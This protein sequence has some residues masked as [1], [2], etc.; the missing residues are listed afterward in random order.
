MRSKTWPE[1]RKKRIELDGGVCINCGESD[2]LHVH[3]VVPLSKG[4]KDAMSNLRTL[5]DGCHNNAHTGVPVP[6]KLT[7]SD[8]RWLP[9][10]SEVQRTLDSTGHPLKR[11]VFMLFAKIGV[12]VNDL[13]DLKVTDLRIKKN[14]FHDEDALTLDPRDGVPEHIII[15]GHESPAPQGGGRLSTA[16]VPLDRETVHELRRWLAIR[17]DSRGCESLFLST[18]K[19]GEPLTTKAARSIVIGMAKDVGLYEEGGGKYNLT[20]SVLRMFFEDRFQGQPAVREYIVG[21]KKSPPFSFDRIA[22]DYREGIYK[23]V[24]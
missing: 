5:C 22:T 16:K 14:P 19:W 1:T 21:K 17:P 20:P 18:N 2:R 15:S 9:T 4:G 8:T 11:A 6:D 12:G 10:I 3:H 23:L 13:P 7:E 24:P